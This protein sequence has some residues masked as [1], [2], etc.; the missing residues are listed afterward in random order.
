MLLQILLFIGISFG[1]AC[2]SQVLAPLASPIS[3]PGAASSQPPLSVGVGVA[4]FGAASQQNKTILIE[5]PSSLL[6]AGHGGMLRFGSAVADQQT[7]KNQQLLGQSSAVTPPTSVDGLVVSMCR[8]GSA[9]AKAAPSALGDGSVQLG[10]VKE[11][12]TED[13]SLILASFPVPSASTYLQ[14]AFEFGTTVGEQ[15]ADMADVKDKSTSSR[16]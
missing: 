10:R 1:N 11:V 13:P 9:L 16:V 4:R 3:L 5:P 6:S 14:A 2:H 15:D 7:D 8:F 12:T